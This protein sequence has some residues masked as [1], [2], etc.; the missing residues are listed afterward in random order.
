MIEDSPKGIENQIARLREQ[1]NYHNHKYHTLD[2]PE[3]KDSEFDA[4]FEELKSLESR[5]PNLVTSD[6]PTQRM[7]SAPLES[8]SQVR[9]ERPMLSLE[10]AF[11]EKDL[12]DFEKRVR[13]IF[14]TILSQLLLVSRR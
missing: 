4:L 2:A 6:S 13:K 12:D 14:Q 9:H 8:F 11:T 3:I 1:I 5:N 7:G 10:N